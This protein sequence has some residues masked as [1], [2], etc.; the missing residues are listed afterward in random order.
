MD[1]WGNWDYIGPGINNGQSEIKLA[2]LEFSRPPEVAN[3]FGVDEGSTGLV[4]VR[5]CPCRQGCS[6]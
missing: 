4:Q 1:K 2:Q 5:S 3:R 6:P